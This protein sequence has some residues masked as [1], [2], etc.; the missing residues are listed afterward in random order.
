M[1]IDI[2]TKIERW[3]IKAEL[4]LKNNIKCFLKTINGDYHSADILL[5]DENTIL[6]YDFIK[7]EKFKVYWADVILFDEY[8]EKEELKND[9]S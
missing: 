9:K 2:E 7:Q 4:F 5:V 6:I 3:R 8:K 1:D